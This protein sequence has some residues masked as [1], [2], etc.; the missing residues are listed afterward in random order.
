[1]SPYGFY[2]TIRFVASIG[3]IF[4][5]AALLCLACGLAVVHDLYREADFHH[6]YGDNWKAVY[7]ERY[8]SLTEEHNHIALSAVSFVALAA[9][10]TWFVKVLWQNMGGR[11]RRKHSK[12]SYSAASPIERVMRYRRKALLG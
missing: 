3:I 2:R 8:G 11:P 12:H 4:L 5:F 7:E 6:R 10:G 1:M 9:A